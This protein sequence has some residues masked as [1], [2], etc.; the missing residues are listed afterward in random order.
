MTV[1]SVSPAGLY[2]GLCLS[3]V[4]SNRGHKLSRKERIETLN[5]FKTSALMRKR[6]HNSCCCCCCFLPPFLSPLRFNKA[7]FCLVFPVWLKVE[8]FIFGSP[9]TLSSWDEKGLQWV[10]TFGECP[11]F[12]ILFLWAVKQW[13]P[14]FQLYQDIQMPWACKPSLS[15][16]LYLSGCSP[17]LS[18]WQES[19]FISSSPLCI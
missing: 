4:Q 16:F 11:E 8:R 6:V 3:M 5:V 14:K 15:L 12:C 17:S 19:C 18:F 10:F 1:T 7:N 2:L 13:E 9:L